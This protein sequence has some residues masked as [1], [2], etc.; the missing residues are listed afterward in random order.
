MQ[1]VRPI[2]PGAALLA[3]SVGL[4][5]AFFS[6]AAPHRAVTFSESPSP[7][8]PGHF[9]NWPIPP[10]TTGE[11]LHLI[12]ACGY[13]VKSVEGAGGGTTGAEKIVLD[14][15]S[16][17]GDIPLKSKRAPRSLD[18]INNAP[19]K[20]LAAYAIQAL[21]LDPE[22][23]VVPTTFA[24]CIPLGDW[25]AHHRSGSATI[26]GTNCVLVVNALWLDDVTLPNP[27]YDGERFLTDPVYAYH[28]SNFNIL[29]YVI[30]HRDGREGNFLVSKDDSRRQVFAID[31]GSTFNPIGYNYF[32]PNWDKIR[33]AA[34]RRETVDRLRELDRDDLDFLEV[35]DQ[36]ELDEN[37]ILRHVPP[38]KSMDE[39]EG[40]VYEDGTLQFGLTEDEID[41]I[42]DRIEDLVDAVDD[43]DLPVF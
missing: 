22:D 18:G 23:Y 3:A 34:V 41:A 5:C 39:D 1:A 2:A 38:G 16:E 30:G 14:C 35:V 8:Q 17:G 10:A 11:S 36:L 9:P 25:S 27:L 21:L 4:G 31:N 13:D 42:W 32:V 33:V 37:G 12:E 43:E 15:P 20:E 7:S 28:M 40:V 26:G 19:R 29:T 6:P 24:S